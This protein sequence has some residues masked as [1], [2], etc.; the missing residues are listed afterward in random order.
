MCRFLQAQT[1]RNDAHIQANGVYERTDISLSQHKTARLRHGIRLGGVY[2]TE[3]V[4]KSFGMP[5]AKETM[6]SFH[7]KAVSHSCLW[8][9]TA[10]RRPHDDQYLSSIF[11]IFS[12]RFFCLC[13]LK[14]NESKKSKPP[15]RLLFLRWLYLSNFLS[16][17]LKPN[18]GL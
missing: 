17:V 3:N 8:R 15:I 1:A 4:C 9:Q 2:F 5:E 7:N 16:F 18:F 14:F 12:R 11:L 6:E 13:F 10:V